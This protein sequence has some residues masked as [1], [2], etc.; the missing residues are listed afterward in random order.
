M[1]A[2]HPR[3]ATDRNGEAVRQVI[4][5][6]KSP[7]WLTVEDSAGGV[8]LAQQMRRGQLYRVPNEAGLLV[9][10][11]NAAA[12]EYY[13]E[14]ELGGLLGDATGGLSRFPVARL[15]AAAAGG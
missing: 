15:T 12:V 11:D 8:L 9:S 6:A 1:M 14:G 7:V 10:A 5:R 13:V 4:L 3:A 2:T